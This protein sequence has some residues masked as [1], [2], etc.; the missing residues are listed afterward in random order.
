VT[1]VERG[2]VDRVEPFGQGDKRRV[3]EPEPLVG[4]ALGDP[5][6]GGD[7]AGPPL[8]EVCASGKVGP[9]RA[10]GCSAV[11]RRHELVNLNLPM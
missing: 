5:H 3:Y 7:R 8:D 6:R 11:T 2:D 9:E 4:V 10:D 1:L